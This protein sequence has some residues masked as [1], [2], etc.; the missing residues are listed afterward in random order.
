LT[1]TQPARNVADSVV[2]MTEIVLPEDTNPHGSV[3]GGRVLA[4]IDKCAAVVAMRHA[5]R[6]AVT[7][8]L[9]SVTFLTKVQL[10]EVLLLHG[11]LNAAFGSSMEIEVQVH[12]ENPLTGE[13]RLT[14]TAFVTMVAVDPEG[15]P[16]S[17]P[18]LVAASDEERARAAQAAERRAKRLASRA[19]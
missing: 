2:Q 4:L 7:V 15:R 10:G 16:A 8:S 1:A 11:R 19:G 17:V 14:T 13:R 18:P 3:F 12:A 6:E 5:R 9:D